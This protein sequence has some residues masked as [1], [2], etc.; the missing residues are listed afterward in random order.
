MCLGFLLSEPLLNHTGRPTTGICKHVASALCMLAFPWPRAA[1]SALRL[2]FLLLDQATCLPHPLFQFLAVLLA[3][4]ASA[5]FARGRSAE[6]HTKNKNT[7]KNK[8]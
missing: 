1:F 7:R 3:S 8:H 4:S 5:R 6:Q 2:L